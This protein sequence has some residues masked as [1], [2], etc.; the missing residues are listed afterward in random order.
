[1]PWR[2]LSPNSSI[3]EWTM[4]SNN[5]HAPRTLIARHGITYYSNV[6]CYELTIVSSPTTAN[7]ACLDIISYFFTYFEDS[8]RVDDELAGLGI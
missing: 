2:G 5:G 4:D 6:S 3:L 1:M 8:A 7:R